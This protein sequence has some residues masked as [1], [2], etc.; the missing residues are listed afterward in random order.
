MVAGGWTSDRR[1]SALGRTSVWRACGVGTRQDLCLACARRRLEYW[2]RARGVGV[3]ATLTGG[4]RVGVSWRR[5]ACASAPALAGGVRV[6]AGVGWKRWLE[7]LA[8]LDASP[9]PRRRTEQHR[10]GIGLV[11]C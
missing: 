9:N 7:A 5:A 6:G 4:V 1:A 8:W 11:G 10:P 3:G 2:R